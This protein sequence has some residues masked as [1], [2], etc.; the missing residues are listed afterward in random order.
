M[1]GKFL[2]T[3]LAIIMPPLC[4]FSIKGWGKQCFYSCVLTILAY[5]P[6]LLYALY[7]IHKSS[8]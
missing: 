2:N 8:E 6:G 5:F 1:A 3:I 4:V 7:I